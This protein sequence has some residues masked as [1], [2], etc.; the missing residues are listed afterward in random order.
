MNDVLIN[1][2]LILI[3]GDLLDTTTVRGN[4]IVGGAQLS[5][6]VWGLWTSLIQA[7]ATN[8]IEQVNINIG[9][10]DAKPPA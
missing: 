3:L 4:D 1:Q 5:M 10:R 6:Q 8:D 2:I 9:I 7:V